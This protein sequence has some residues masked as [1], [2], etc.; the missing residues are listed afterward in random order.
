M[1]LYKRGQVWWMRF[2]YNGKQIRKPTETID[3]K[4]AEKI[5]HK[6]MAEIAEGKW[7]ERPLGA[8]K[9]ISEL[10][11]KYITDYSARNNTGTTQER[12]KYIVKR[13]KKF[14]GEAVLSQ[15]GPKHIAEYKVARRNEGRAPSTI[16]R[17]LGL[18]GHGSTLPSRS[19]NGLIPT[20]LLVSLV[21]AFT[22]SLNAG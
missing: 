22:T 12:D 8:D 3:R 13:F 1:G 7:F 16:N 9:T 6:V 4:L 15:I 17:E 14:F 20:R 18:L 19:G 21:S 11:D 10:L 5:Y 2:T